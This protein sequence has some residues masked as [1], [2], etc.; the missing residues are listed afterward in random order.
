MNSSS[1][2]RM[3]RSRS[4]FWKRRIPPS[5]LQSATSATDSSTAHGASRIT[6]YVVRV[7]TRTPS[8]SISAKFVPYRSN[9]EMRW[10]PI[11]TNMKGSNRTSVRKNVISTFTA[12]R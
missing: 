1:S 4:S 6:C 5:A 3:K 9:L 10:L 7:S 12:L 2:S 8:R 11:G